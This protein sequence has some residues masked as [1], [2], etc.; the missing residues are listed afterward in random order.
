M[1]LVVIRQ[2]PSIGDCL[3]LAPLI[4]QL[5][6][7]YEGSHLSVVTD[8]QY[9]SGALPKVFEGIPGVDHIECIDS[10]EWTTE[11]N[12]RIDPALL[13]A[14]TEPLPYTVSHA[15]K[16]L[17]C[18]AAFME[19]ERTYGGKPPHGI[20]EFWLRHHCLYHDGVNLLPVY[21]V[22][23]Q[24]QQ[25]ADE[26]IERN[27]PTGRPMVGVVMRAG[28]PVRDWDFDGRSSMIAAYLHTSGYLPVGIDPTKTL[29]SIYAV[30]C[31]GKQIDFVAGIIKRMRL[32]LTPDTG[33]LHLA[34][35]VGTPQ[36]ALW[37]IMPPEL[38]MK[39]YDCIVVPKKSL[40]FCKDS[41][42]LRSCKCHWKFQQWSCIHRITPTMIFNALGEALR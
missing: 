22:P 27:N 7:V 18:N 34:Q 20:A 28:N 42:E 32:I 35:A 38:R 36:V 26:W 4:Q 21:E 23:E 16:V 6:K 9:L 1:K 30:S 17:D 19:F 10:R 29:N 33:L 40:G 2:R 5:K 14:A 15:N 13:G 24:A 12:R 25:A 37:G 11:P 8:S 39:G 3:L 41:D 31:I